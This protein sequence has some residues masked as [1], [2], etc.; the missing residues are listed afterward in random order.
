MD[1]YLTWLFNIVSIDIRRSPYRKMLL[2]LF[3]RE[4]VWSINYD[5]NREEDG[6]DLRRKF[7]DETGCDPYFWRGLCTDT[8]SVV[9]VMIALSVR[10]D[11]EVY[12]PKYGSRTDIWFWEMIK[13]IGLEHMIDSCFDEEKCRILV[14]D[15]LER[16]YKKD[17]NGGLFVTKNDKI[18]MRKSEIWYQTAIWI[19][20]NFDI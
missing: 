3:N 5:D 8:S 12:D 1:E 4:F 19:E 18:D 11:D 13:T 2:Y 16:R 7:A 14:D 17:G 9:E 6:F 15:L 20:E 10:I